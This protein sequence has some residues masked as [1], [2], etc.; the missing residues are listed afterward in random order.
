M[1]EKTTRN[2][3]QSFLEKENL[4]WEN[5]TKVYENVYVIKA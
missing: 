3:N 4:P 1:A 2:E 5:K